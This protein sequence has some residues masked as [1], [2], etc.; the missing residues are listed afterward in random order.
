MVYQ[1]PIHNVIWL[2]CQFSCR[3][4]WTPGLCMITSS[5]SHTHIWRCSLGNANRRGRLNKTYVTFSRVRFTT[6]HPLV[7]AVQAYTNSSWRAVS[8]VSGRSQVR[9]L[10]TF[11]RT[12]RGFLSR[13]SLSPQS[14]YERGSPQTVIRLT[15]MGCWFWESRRAG[16]AQEHH[17]RVQPGECGGLLRD[18]RR[19]REVRDDFGALGDIFFM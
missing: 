19:T 8:V 11:L 13:V 12:T 4:A 10:W 7:K 18:W 5:S 16:S 2:S 6:F 17:D 15:E 3:G 9:R 14:E 1:Q